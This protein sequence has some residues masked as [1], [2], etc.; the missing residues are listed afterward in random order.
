MIDF[1]TYGT[2]EYEAARDRG[3]FMRKLA[4][5]GLE[6]LGEENAR[7]LVKQKETIQ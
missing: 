6:H 7:E 5:I 2:A 1:P 4:D 3:A